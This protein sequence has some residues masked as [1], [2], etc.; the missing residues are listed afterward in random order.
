VTTLSDDCGAY[1][2]Y[3][4]TPVNLD[5][6]V[7]LVSKGDKKY[8]LWMICTESAFDLRR[9]R[10]V[11]LKTWQRIFIDISSTFAFVTLPKPTKK[12]V[13]FQIADTFGPNTLISKDGVKIFRPMNLSS[14]A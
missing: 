5:E 3:F 11:E 12:E 7:K 2:L 13:L 10:G 6:F 4:K 8:G 9:L 1:E 14:S